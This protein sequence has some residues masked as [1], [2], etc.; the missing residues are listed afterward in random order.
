MISVR[1]AASTDAAD[2]VAVRLASWRATYGPYLPPHVWDDF[3]PAARAARLAASIEAGSMRV[4]VAAA[5]ATVVGYSFSGACRDDDVPAGT[6][7]VYAIYVQPSSWSTGAGRA[8]M[9]ATL[10]SF[11]EVPVVLWVLEVNA[12]ARR[13]YELAGFVADGTV[14]PAEMPG[15]VTLPELRYRRT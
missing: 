11:G 9:S 13:F 6:G 8:L 10:D 14:K 7:E 1:P 2:I 15:G 5:D 3:D 4:L 12:R